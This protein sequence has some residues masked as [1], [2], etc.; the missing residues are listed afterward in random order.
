[1]KKGKP[2]LATRFWAGFVTE[3][4]FEAFDALFDFAHLDY[5]KRNLSEAVLHCYKNTVY[6]QEAPSNVFVFYTAISSFVKICYCLKGKDKTWNVKESSRSDT[7]FHLTSLTKMEHD[8]PFTVLQ[9]AF[10]ELTLQQFDYF[11]SEITTLSLSP[12]C[13]DMTSD[14]LT[15]YIH[16]IKMLDAAELI[17]ERG[18]EKI[19]KSNKTKTE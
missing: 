7:V 4:P 19:G 6:Q 1:M 3:D 10:G 18:L 14:L 11:L 12:G 2:S 15:P 17:R 9:K 13:D 16:L 8:H 5:Y